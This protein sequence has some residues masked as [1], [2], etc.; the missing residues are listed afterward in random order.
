MIV[1]IKPDSRGLEPAIQSTAETLRFFL[2][3]RVGAHGCPV[4]FAGFGA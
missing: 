1:K 2:D 4:H 3:G